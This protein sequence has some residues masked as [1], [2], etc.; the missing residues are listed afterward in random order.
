MRPTQQVQAVGLEEAQAE[1]PEAQL[2]AV[3]AS[4]LVR[5]EGPP[6]WAPVRIMAWETA[7]AARMPAPTVCQTRPAT[8]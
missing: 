3:P 7:Q 1:R 8:A 6:V 4:E 5:R 2:A